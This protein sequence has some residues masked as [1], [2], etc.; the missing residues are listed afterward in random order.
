MRYGLTKLNNDL[1][2]S[3]SL[4][5]DSDNAELRCTKEEVYPAQKRSQNPLEGSAE[6]GD[7]CA[8]LG[9]LFGSEILN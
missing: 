6:I 9:P 8:A 7:A 3:F 4:K 2:Q 1:R 5:Y